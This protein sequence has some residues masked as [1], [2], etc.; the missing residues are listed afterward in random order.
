MT[1]A[2]FLGRHGTT[3]EKEG[4]V[5][6]EDE[7]KICELVSDKQSLASVAPSWELGNQLFTTSSRAKVN[8]KRFIPKSKT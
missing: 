6:I 2:A 1:L 3:Q 7:L 4:C 8:F 5:D